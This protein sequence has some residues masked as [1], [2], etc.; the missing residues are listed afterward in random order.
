MGML[1]SDASRGQ[2]SGCF[3]RVRTEADQGEVA[4]LHGDELRPGG[5]F[6]PKFRLALTRGRSFPW[7]LESHRV[8]SSPLAPGIALAGLKARSP[9]GKWLYCTAMSPS[10]A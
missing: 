8:R 1:I 2:L 3:N 6:V 7:I 5:R 4:R 9:T 10:E